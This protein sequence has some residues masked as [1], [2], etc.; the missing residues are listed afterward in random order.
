MI[1]STGR[2]DEQPDLKKPTALRGAVGV[3]DRESGGRIK[4]CDGACFHAINSLAGADSW[5]ITNVTAFT[6]FP[7]LLIP[8]GSASRKT[9]Y[10]FPT[11]WCDCYGA[12]C[13]LAPRMMLSTCF[14]S[15]VN[16][17]FFCASFH[18]FSVIEERILFASASAS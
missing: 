5:S 1:S 12:V 10:Q 11:V 14:L 17:N 7:H 3:W 13:E 2:P 6:F 4:G 18:S 8:P 9:S 15:K 16:G